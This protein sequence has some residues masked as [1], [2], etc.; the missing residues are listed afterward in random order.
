MGN[1]FRKP[2]DAQGVAPEHAPDVAA[3]HFATSDTAADAAPTQEPVQPVAAASQPIP[4][5]IIPTLMLMFRRRLR[6]R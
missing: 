3:A 6:R 1:H 4:L 2:E 5:P